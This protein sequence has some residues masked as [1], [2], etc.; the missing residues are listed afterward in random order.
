MRCFWC[1]FPCVLVPVCDRE[2]KI[3][4]AY[5]PKSIWFEFFSDFLIGESAEGGRGEDGGGQKESGN[6]PPETKRSSK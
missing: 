5:R 2:R 1:T 3:M 6:Q 4:L